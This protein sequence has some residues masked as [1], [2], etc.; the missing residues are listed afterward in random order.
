MATALDVVNVARSQIGQQENPRG[1]NRISYNN[2]YVEEGYG[3]RDYLTAAWCAIFVSWCASRV[4]ASDIIPIHAYTPTGLN[5]FEKRGLVSR[6]NSPTIGSLCYVNYPGQSDRVGHV[7]IVEAVLSDGT[8]QTIEGNTNTDGSATGYGVFRL[9]RK[10]NNRLYFAH[11]RY[12]N[13]RD[14]EQ[15]KLSDI[16]GKDSAGKPITVGQALARGAHAY[17]A[18]FQSGW[19]GSRVH[20]LRVDVDKI[21][22]RLNKFDLR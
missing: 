5:W 8:V 20:N 3:S 6:G 15:M 17:D 1:T 10:V 2:W 13:V 19:L 7:G 9:R 22:D 4:G 21:N 16:V 12:Q 11:P 14:D 18:I